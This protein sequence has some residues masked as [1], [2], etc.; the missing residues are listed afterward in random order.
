MKSSLNEEEV[1][2][3]SCVSNKVSSGYHRRGH[4][5]TRNKRWKSTHACCC[6]KLWT[7]QCS[8]DQR[9]D[10][11]PHQSIVL[12][13]GDTWN[14]NLHTFKILYFV[15]VMMNLY[16]LMFSLLPLWTPKI[17]CGEKKSLLQPF[18]KYNLVYMQIVE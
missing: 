7:C 14:K 10:Q 12:S 3:E 1:G 16:N 5:D 8:D 13:F 4:L 17:I 18:E 9:I 11:L 6:R 15:F 2:A